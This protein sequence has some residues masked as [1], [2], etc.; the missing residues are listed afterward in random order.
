VQLCKS[1]ITDDLYDCLE[2][3]TAQA[4]NTLIMCDTP[5]KVKQGVEQIIIENRETLKQLDIPPSATHPCPN[6]S[7][8]MSRC[9]SSA[10]LTG[11]HFRDFL[12]FAVAHSHIAYRLGLKPRF[13]GFK[14]APIY[15]G[16]R[17]ITRAASWTSPSFQK[18]RYM[19]HYEDLFKYPPPFRL[20]SYP[21]EIPDHIYCTEGGSLLHE[22]VRTFS[23]MIYDCKNP[24]FDFAAKHV[25][26]HGEMML[27][28][29]EPCAGFFVS[30]LCWV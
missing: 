2:R 6:K 30:I 23:P 28:T 14:I 18:T 15:Q 19:W 20:M 27:C 12:E 10:N 8:H 13:E 25:L 22:L 17:V 11:D 5:E 26:T 29:H 21:E 9:Y 7:K 16:F 1:I 24:N 3:L 4:V